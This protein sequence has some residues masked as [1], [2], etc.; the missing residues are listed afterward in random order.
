MFVRNLA[1]GSADADSRDHLTGCR[2]NGRC[3][4][5]DTSLVFFIIDCV[6]PFSGFHKI[7]QQPV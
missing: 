5:P 3:N 4:A 6:A 2:S 7:I 1:D